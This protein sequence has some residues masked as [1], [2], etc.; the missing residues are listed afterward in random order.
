MTYVQP[1][2]RLEPIEYV[3]PERCHAT[4]YSE[5]KQAVINASDYIKR[6]S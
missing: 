3:Y 5:S 1:I 4:A 2:L 6:I